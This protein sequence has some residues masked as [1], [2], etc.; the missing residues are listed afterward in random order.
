MELLA[1]LGQVPLP[2]TV[3]KASACVLRPPLALAAARAFPCLAELHLVDGPGFPQLEALAGT[4]PLLLGSNATAT[5]GLLPRLSALTLEEA[6]LALPH[7][8]APGQPWRLESVLPEALGS[9]LRDAPQLRCLRLRLLRPYAAPNA[10]LLGALTQLQALELH[11]PPDRCPDGPS[12]GPGAADSGVAGGPAEPYTELPEL[13]AAVRRLTGLRRLAL[14]GLAC[15][16]P[17]PAAA[18][19]GLPHLRE[20]VLPSQ[21]L[22]VGG[23]QA[24]TALTCLAVGQLAAPA[25]SQAPPGI[26]SAGT[27]A[28]PGARWALPPALAVLEL[29][30]P[31][32]AP[33]VVA[34][35]VPPPALE[36]VA[37]GAV[38]TLAGLHYSHRGL[39]LTQ[40]G[41]AALSGALRFLAGR[42]PPRAALTVGAD[43]ASAVLPQRRPAAPA[44]PASSAAPAAPACGHGAWLSGLR[45][46]RLR[47]L[48]LRSLV[49]AAADFAELARAC[50]ELE[51]LSLRNCELP[52]SEREAA[53]VGAALSTGWLRELSLDVCRWLVWPEE[54]EDEDGWGGRGLY[55]P[56]RSPGPP[57]FP[58]GVQP[59]LLALVRALG[60]GGG[61]TSL[62]PVGPQESS[63][64]GLGP[65]ALVRAVEVDGS[66]QP[67]RPPPRVV[68]RSPPERGEACAACAGLAERLR[69]ALAREGLDP[70]RLAAAAW[71]G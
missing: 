17:L 1:R 57:R 64:L 38:G 9:A 55:D 31:L 29:L 67:V 23:L 21:E 70:E 27:G 37:C 63:E 62:G 33:E 40:E 65:Q 4:L 71:S 8:P 45:P 43:I 34:A 56:G 15:E 52:E 47:C 13:L 22:E 32:A 12:R 42:L 11:A 59:W 60:G 53:A 6:P 69:S 24:L 54:E 5:P 25:W 51:V 30:H 19:A 66:S 44:G 61:G 58:D 26:T 16:A 50:G 35:L 7:R 68:L 48:T 39:E 46:L 2:T 36:R 10:A 18:F 3:F 41:E 49:L 28:G 14:E 20:L